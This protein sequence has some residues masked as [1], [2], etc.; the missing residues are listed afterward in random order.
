MRAHFP[1]RPPPL[2]GSFNQPSALPRPVPEDG[3]EESLGA[4]SP[5]SHGGRGRFGEPL[6]RVRSRAGAARQPARLSGNSPARLRQFSDLNVSVGGSTLRVVNQSQE[7]TFN[8]QGLWRQTSRPHEAQLEQPVR[9]T[10][11]PSRTRPPSTRAVLRRGHAG[12]QRHRQRRE[13]HRT[14]ASGAL[15]AAVGTQPTTRRC[16]RLSTAPPTASWR[17]SA[18][19][20]STRRAAH[21]APR[22][23]PAE[24]ARR[25][26]ARSSSPSCGCCATA[27]R[28]ALTA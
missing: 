24:R 13:Q 27:A 8:P 23:C 22:P 15:L 14:P 26:A 25:I 1:A 12:V 4:P 19:P 21:A 11:F 9:R 10:A 7:F 2:Q 3:P 20:S 16:A 6:S 28:P 18:S 17:S 5:V